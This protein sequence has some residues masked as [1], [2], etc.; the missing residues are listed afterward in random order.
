MVRILDAALEDPCTSMSSMLL[1]AKQWSNLCAKLETVKFELRSNGRSRRT[2]NVVIRSLGKYFK[3]NSGL[4]CMSLKNVGIYHYRLNPLL[5]TLNRLE[6][7]TLSGLSQH[8]QFPLN[9]LSRL[10]FLALIDCVVPGF[11][12]VPTF[13]NLRE[14][15]IVDTHGLPTLHLP[16]LERLRLQSNRYAERCPPVIWGSLESLTALDIS[17]TYL[18]EEEVSEWANSLSLLTKLT[19]LKAPSI[20][21]ESLTDKLLDSARGSHRAGRHFEAVKLYTQAMRVTDAGVWSGCP[22]MGLD[23]VQATSR[24][25]WQVVIEYY[26]L[27]AEL[28]SREGLTHL[29]ECFLNG[30]GVDANEEEGL[31]YLRLAAK[32]GCVDAMYT[33]GEV[34]KKNEF[35]RSI[36]RAKCFPEVVD[37]DESGA[38]VRYFRKSSYVKNEPRFVFPFIPL[39]T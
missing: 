9:V 24:E 2:L 15:H 30:W 6:S 13:A 4:K 22:V 14:L 20:L 36:D 38:I 31:K 27:V 33:I 3:D 23:A 25:E 17:Q 5:S 21:T 39:P 1:V 19:L 26:R 12:H 7:L 16:A 10:K 34:E 28:G 35:L 37:S 32:E 8:K 11:P 18:Y 29:G